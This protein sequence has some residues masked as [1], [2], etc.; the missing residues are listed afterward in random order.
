MKF[1][2]FVIC[3]WFSATSHAQTWT[4]L[5]KTNIQKILIKNYFGFF[6]YFKKDSSVISVP[7]EMESDFSQL[8]VDNSNAFDSISRNCTGFSPYMIGDSLQNYFVE[9]HVKYITFFVKR[10]VTEQGGVV[11]W[12]M[13]NMYGDGQPCWPSITLKKIGTGKTSKVEFI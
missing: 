4:Q 6:T 10:T 12:L 9:S 8:F 11:V 5:P 7:G 1:I 3:L 13:T 2:L